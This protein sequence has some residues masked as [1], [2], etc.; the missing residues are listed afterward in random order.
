MPDPK[1]LSRMCGFVKS[2]AVNAGFEFR[3]A[4]GVEEAWVSQVLVRAR[5]PH[6]LE[7]VREAQRRTGF[8]FRDAVSEEF[9][10]SLREVLSEN[11]RDP[12]EAVKGF[13][14]EVQESV[15]WE[16]L[17]PGVSRKFLKSEWRRCLEHV[18][19]PV[20]LGWVD[21]E[22]DCQACGACNK[23]EREAITHAR[24]PPRQDLDALERRVKEL[25]RSETVV[26]VEVEL[27]DACQ[28]LARDLVESRLASALM[29]HAPELVRGYRH[30]EPDP[31]EIFL[32]TGRR[33]LRPVLLEEA[34]ETLRTLL[35]DPDF[36]ERT[37]RSFA[38][39]G[40][41]LG[42][43]GTPPTRVLLRGSAPLDPGGWVASRGLKHTFRKD[44]S[45]RR[46]EFP[47]ETLKKRIV[48]GLVRA[49]S[50]E[51]A[52]IRIEIDEKFDV[53][54]FLKAVVAPEDRHAVTVRWE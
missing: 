54:E 24:Q 18:Q 3:G 8:L 42:S 35:R 47:K 17:N 38:S 13:D 12:D 15:P 10:K 28:G 29:T 2:V 49:E 9:Y 6:I 39:L 7:A 46:W 33:I 53:K 14:P 34:A 5:G 19:T 11:D 36:L 16:D 50:D 41:V 31:E 32:S 51:G 4:A 52:E 37:T 21:E 1:T 26:E 27:S 22:G 20:C 44:G 23:E 43:P 25:R 40:R 30:H 45:T 48:R